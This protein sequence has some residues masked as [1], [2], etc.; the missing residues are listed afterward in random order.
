MGRPRS[1]PT[2]DT[3]MQWQMNRKIATDSSLAAHAQAAK[4]FITAKHVGT[5]IDME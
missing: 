5:K 3:Q 1:F 2:E 4:P